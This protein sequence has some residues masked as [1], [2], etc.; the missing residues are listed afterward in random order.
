MDLVGYSEE[1]YRE[2]QR[3]FAAVLDYL[4]LPNAYFLAAS[5]LAGDNIVEP[6]RNMPWF[7]GL[8]LLE[9]L[10]TVNVSDTDGAFRLPVQL[11]VRPDLH[12]RGYAGQIASGSVKVG[13]RVAIWPGGKETAV[14]RIVTYDGDLTEASAPQSV[15]LVLEHE[16]DIA[17]GSLIAAADEAPTS[18]RRFRADVVWMRERPLDRSRT[19][20]IKHGTRSVRASLVKLTE[21]FDVNTLKREPASSL[22]L[23]DIGVAEFE[24]VSTLHFD[25]YAGSRMMGAFILIDPE[26]HETVGA[27]MI[28]GSVQSEFKEVSA[29]ERATRFGHGAGVVRLNGRRALALRLER[30]IFDRGGFAVVLDRAGAAALEALHAGG[31]IAIVVDEPGPARSQDDG[32]ACNQIL[33]ELFVETESDVTSGEAI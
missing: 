28:R 6:S 22:Q 26:T 25:S 16:I 7:K 4:K 29:R 5:A 10:E 2:I 24:A 33:R 32:S 8:P 15:T 30:R 3:D 9:Y 18:S 21:R 1:R 12:F 11:V 27:G 20:I 23:N 31:V 13:D 17:R 14:T 19:W